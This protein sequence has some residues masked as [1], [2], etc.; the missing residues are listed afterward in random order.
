VRYKE[1]H[2]GPHCKV[3]PIQGLSAESSFEA[4]YG[5]SCVAMSFHGSEQ[6]RRSLHPNDED[7]SMGTPVLHPNDEDLSMG[8]PVLMVAST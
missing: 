8:T 3:L 5:N 1:L 7:L 2:G 6:G 4:I